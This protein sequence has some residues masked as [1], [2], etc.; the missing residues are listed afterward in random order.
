MKNRVK[1]LVINLVWMLFSFSSLA[2]DYFVYHFTGKVYF[3]DNLN[4]KSIVFYNYPVAPT[5]RFILEQNAELIIR[6]KSYNLLIIKEKGEYTEKDVRQ[7]Y[8]DSKI[9]QNFA[10]SVYEFIVAE[11]VNSTGDIERYAERNMQQKG[12]VSRG[13]INFDEIYPLNGQVMANDNLLFKWN[14]FASDS[15]YEFKISNSNDLNS[16]RILFSHITNDTLIRYSDLSSDIML[17]R[18]PMYWGVNIKGQAACQRK[19]FQIMDSE[20]YS[21]L[22]ISLQDSIDKGASIID[23]LV[24]LAVKYE[25]NGLIQEAIDCYEFAFKSSGNY[26]FLTLALLTQARHN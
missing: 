4:A 19:E 12:G 6:D 8:N 5:T 24:E 26:A 11:T 22:R 15:Q 1:L 21:T 3:V 14:S 7:I 9:K 25:E 10:S 18:Q 17:V 20:K 13:C 16:E 2:Q 23:Q